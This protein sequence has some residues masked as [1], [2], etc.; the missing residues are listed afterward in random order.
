MEN[1][2]N[3]QMSKDRQFLHHLYRLIVP[4]LAHID[5]GVELLFICSQV[6]QSLH[7]DKRENGSTLFYT[8]FG[9]PESCR[10][11]SMQLMKKET[12][13]AYDSPESEVFMLKIE[14]N[15]AATQTEPIDDDPIEHDL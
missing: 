7:P 13:E 8:G 4:V 2:V 3:F 9:T 15:F 6:Y 10:L 11:F 1:L 5:T 14:K 12:R